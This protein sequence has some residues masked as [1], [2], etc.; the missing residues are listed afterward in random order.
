MYNAFFF[1][2][3]QNPG[4][5]THPCVDYVDNLVDPEKE[6]VKIIDLLGRETGFKANKPLIYIYSDG[7]VEKLIKTR[8]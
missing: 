5:N 4:N 8:P 7:S 6:L 2:Q 3:I 1:P